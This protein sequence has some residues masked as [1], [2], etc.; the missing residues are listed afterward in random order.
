MPLHACE[1]KGARLRGISFPNLTGVQ[2]IGAERGLNAHPC[3][4]T[5]EGYC[6][7]A[8]GAGGKCE[9]VDISLGVNHPIGLKGFLVRQLAQVRCVVE[10]PMIVLCVPFRAI[11]Q[12]AFHIGLDVG[13][14]VIP[15]TPKVRGM[16]GEVDPSPLSER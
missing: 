4:R 3:V 10:H 16:D 8:I 15:V 1:H 2:G 5:G 12:K 11:S 13:A 9:G 7:P 6:D 14:G